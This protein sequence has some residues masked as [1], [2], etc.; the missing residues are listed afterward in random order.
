MVAS[1]FGYWSFGYVKAYRYYPIVGCPRYSV[2]IGVLGGKTSGYGLGYVS[3]CSV[4]VS[5]Y[6]VAAGVEY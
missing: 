6:Y 5:C 2:D 4:Y 1:Y 3:A